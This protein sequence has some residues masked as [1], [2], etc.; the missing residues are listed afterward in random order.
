MD[1]NKYADIRA[2]IPSEVPGAIAELM[3]NAEL[4]QI[5]EGLGT[6]ISWEEVCQQ[7]KD[8]QTVEDFKQIFSA[9]LVRH[10]MRN[11]CESVAPLRGTEYITAKGSYTYISNHRDIILD[12]AFLNV[13][14]HDIGAKFPYIAIG[15]NLMVRPWVEPLVKLNGSFLVRRGLQ[16][17]DVLL[18]AKLLSELMHDSI[19]SGLSL[20]IAQREGRA[21]DASDRTQ[22]AL[23]KM[24]SL[25]SG[26]KEALPAL[27]PLNIVP[28]SCSYE[29]DPC[30]YLKAREMQLKRDIPN[31]HK[32]PQEDALNMRT[33]VFG[34]KGRVQFS[35]GR[36]LA[37]LVQTINWTEIEEPKRIEQICYLIDNEIHRNYKLY[38][39]N[40]IAWDR[41]ESSKAHNAFYTKDDQRV[42]EEY[43]QR[44][45]SRIEMP[46]NI[47]LDQAYIEHCLLE[48]YANPARNFVAAHRG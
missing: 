19:A 46:E 9:N 44:Q 4:K 39:I 33:G 17:R 38:P 11:T 48:M 25:G 47:V 2:L 35:I 16:G 1:Y 6:S 21:K 41:L 5:F 29:F 20:W 36:P 23:L 34:Q 32:T 27:A 40:Y 8:C 28:V 14:L 22:G 10:I 3:N 45:I 12:S 13:L 7:L 24:L 18:A 43:I 42:V 31:Y 30:D 26:I 37:D 15:D